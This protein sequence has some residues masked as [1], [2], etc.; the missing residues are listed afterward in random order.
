MHSYINIRPAVAAFD[1]DVTITTRDT[2]VPFLYRAFGQN[3]VRK[4]FLRLAPVAAKVALGL[5]TRD[6]FKAKLIHELFPGE[7]L[8]RLRTVGQEHALDIL[9]WVR[10]AALQRIAWHKQR[11]DRLVM[12]SASL[13]IYLEPVA[14][15]LGF[16]DLLCTRPSLRHDIFDGGMNGKNC[17]GAEKVARLQNLLG[18][19]SL[20]DTYAYG[21]S[22]GDKEMLQIALHPFYRAFEPRGVLHDVAY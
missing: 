9:K 21:D 22:A 8:E 3:K 12:V 18:N 16:D 13:D 4:A 7:S 10:P 2:F 17:R 6:V 11:N 1:F 5:S 15:A 14:T 20:V 19:L